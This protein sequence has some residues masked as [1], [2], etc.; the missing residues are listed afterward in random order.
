[1]SA[2]NQ[3][4]EYVRVRDNPFFAGMRRGDAAGFS[5]GN[6]FEVQ[7]KVAGRAFP[8]SSSDAADRGHKNPLLNFPGEA[9]AGIPST[10]SPPTVILESF[11]QSPSGKAQTASET[12]SSTETSQSDLNESPVQSS[13][14]SVEVSPSAS[15][16]LKG[17]DSVSIGSTNWFGVPLPRTAASFYNGNSP[18]IEV[19][20]PC[21]G[22]CRL[23]MF[24]KAGKD[25]VKAGVPS[26]YLHAVL[27]P[28]SS[29]IGS[30]ASTIMYAFY[31]NETVHNNQF[32]IA[33]VININRSD[34]M[35]SHAELKWLLDSCFVDHSS[36]IFID[37][38]DLS[39]YDLYGS[40]T[41][42]LVNGDK[43][44]SKQ[45][46]LKEAV[47]EILSC[48]KEA[49]CCTLI[50][51]KFVLT[52]PEILAQQ[53]FSQL[54]LA[55]ILMDTGNLT[56]PQSTTKDK[57]TATLLINGAG[58][59]GCDGLYEILRYKTKDVPELKASEVLRKDYKKWTKTVG[60][61]ENPNSSRS[62]STATNIGMSSIGIS[63]A[64]LLVHEAT[65]TED[66][67]EFQRFE[68]LSLLVIV[69]GYYD[70]DKKFKREIL[71]SA[72]SLELL[73]TLIHFM[74]ARA[75]QLP[76]KVLQPLGLPDAM[77]A[78]EIDRI[79]SR[80]TIESLL[81]EFQ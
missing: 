7:R 55:G 17:S 56:N 41:L 24:L 47:V 9:T 66:I 61:D 73:R 81:E 75:N 33:P 23:N 58:R 68:N 2:E 12:D 16:K 76:L 46:A 5:R 64:Q 11:D 72:D 54:L 32:C 19:V 45:E 30:V 79:T 36:L 77:R 26:R 34:F 20:E 25:D 52:S 50:A 60:N 28:Q 63:I 27:G 70:T 4:Q 48:K 6:T 65:S 57:Y 67:L 74:M 44:P 69:S 40:L 42:A 49:S 62:R 3:N 29:D 37:E 53:G 1:M 31:L 10:E 59:F 80:K 78:F 8:R 22:I 43:L 18:R 39:Y 71:I 21:E 51:E 15:S 38:I 14:K 35:S 13:G